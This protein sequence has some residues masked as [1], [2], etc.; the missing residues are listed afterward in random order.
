MTTA[1][2][3]IS[4]ADG[5]ALT[6]VASS[7][8][9]DVRAAAARG[10]AAQPAWAALPLS[11]RE[12]AIERLAT[13]ILERRAEALTLL[14]QEMG[15]SASDNLF[16][17][18]VAAR[19]FTA[20]VILAGRIALAPEKISLSVLDWPGKKVV[21]E[22]VPRGLVGIIA[23]WNYPLA[24]FYKHFFPAVLSGNAVLLKP[25][26]HTPRCGAWFARQCA[27]IFPRDLVQVVQGGSAI[28]E[29]VIDAVD[30]VTFTGSV[31]TGK[32]VAARA[33]ERLIPC[34]VEL[35]GK[36][37]AIVLADCDLDR[38][39]AGILFW[40]THNAGQD[41][42]A[43][44]RVYVE[45]S[46]ADRFVAQLAGAARKLRVAAPGVVGDLGPLQNERQLEI[47]EE[48]VDEAKRLGGKVVCGGT[49]TGHGYG[50][51]P[52]EIDDCTQA[53]RVVRD[54]TFGPVI[55]V[56]RVKDAEEAIAKANDSRYGLN[57]S[58]WTTDLARG[59][60]LA[61]RMEV[62]VA[63]V[64]NHSIAG[65]L[66]EIPWTGVKDTG[67]GVASSRHAYPT[68]VR[69]RTL[70]IDSNRKPDPIWYPGDENLAAFGEALV[71]RGL[72]GGL[73][74]MLKLVGLLGKR[75]KAVQALASGANGA[76]A[77]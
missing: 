10:R 65:A 1:P 71:A 76:S 8:V 47:V 20:S 38:T 19:E 42:S 41:C 2:G 28:G 6:P 29:A 52:T 59:A 35:G 46:I 48:H 3:T 16:H 34:S 55:A 74:A 49:R 5:A 70:F 57:G 32:R 54:E 68:F 77:K 27:E 33:G 4:P 39:V 7:T 73:G 30:A 44:E 75:V 21:V 58:V 24:N 45:A 15:R 53:M 26:E 72:G 67:P 31:P 36:D 61:R 60:A 11:E 66:P 69:R 12:R 25:S 56:I 18:L 13:R 63:F 37:A 22:A 62:G 51:L 43:I 17:E 23:P 14:G 64:N 9:D 40:A 50:Y